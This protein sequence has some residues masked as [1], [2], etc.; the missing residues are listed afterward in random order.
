MTVTPP[1]CSGEAEP[2]GFGCGAATGV[3]PTL[4]M[5]GC[6][7]PGGQV[8]FELDGGTGGAVGFVVEG[9][10]FGVR[11]LGPGCVLRVSGIT[12]LNPIA[13]TG[14]GVGQ[15]T[16]TIPVTIPPTA[17]GTRTYQVFV[18]ATGPAPFFARAALSRDELHGWSDRSS[19]AVPVPR[20]GPGHVGLHAQTE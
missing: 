20:D 8:V 12:A 2:V 14:V 13:L 4:R 15:G 3:V 16:A 19:R 9:T 17:S 18:R 6:A 7:E 11:E 5:S 10:G 1:T